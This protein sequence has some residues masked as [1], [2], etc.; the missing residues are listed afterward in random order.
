VIGIDTN[1]LLRY[2]VQDDRIQSPAAQRF[3]ESQLSQQRTGYVSLPVLA[4]C[5]WVLGSRY[6]A[7][8]AEQ[9]EFVA[10]LLSD[11]RFTVQDSRSAWLALEQAEVHPIDLPD[12]LIAFVNA[13]HGCSHTVTFDRRARAIPGMTLLG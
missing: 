4:E 8:R 12:A 5:L 3:V 10:E 13:H 9:I 7:T 2:V 11:P 6:Q 1:V